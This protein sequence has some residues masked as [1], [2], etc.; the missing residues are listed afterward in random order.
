VGCSGNL[1][2]GP[3]IGSGK[4]GSTDAGKRRR[5][6]KCC[7][8]RE[9]GAEFEFDPAA[10][11]IR[12]TRDL[13]VEYVGRRFEKRHPYRCKE[14]GK[15]FKSIGDSYQRLNGRR[16][17]TSFRKMHDGKACFCSENDVG[18]KMEKTRGD[19]GKGS[20][21][22]ESK[23]YLHRKAPGFYRSSRFRPSFGSCGSFRFV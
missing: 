19:Y 12:K 21:H 5:A 8:C 14:A 23:A 6:G 11:G 13:S 17:E 2:I 7:G 10:D 3:G 20:K 18:C 9:S 4:N 15:A 16:S 1:S 22:D